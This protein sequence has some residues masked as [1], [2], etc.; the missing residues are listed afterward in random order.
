VNAKYRV[1]ITEHEYEPG[2]GATARIDQERDFDNFAEA[3]IFSLQYNSKNN[4]K[5]VPNYY[6]SASRPFLIDLDKD[7]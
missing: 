4:L 5:E 2:W 7:K 6:L 1:T 3:E